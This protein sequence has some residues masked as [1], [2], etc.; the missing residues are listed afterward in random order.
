[1]SA[2]ANIVSGVDWFWTCAGKA[3]AYREADALFSCEG[4][5]IGH[6]RGDEI[7]GRDG[8]YLGEVARTGRLTTKL[9]K[10]RWRKSGFFPSK[11]KSLDPPPDLM[12]ENILAGFKDFK[13]P[14]QLS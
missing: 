5:Q 14:G 3:L 11:N 2:S 8:N 12:S 13:I 1:M 9:S 10:L 6:F 4:R 7:Y